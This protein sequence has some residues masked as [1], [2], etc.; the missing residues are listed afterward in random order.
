MICFYIRFI[1]SELCRGTLDDYIKGSYN[2]PKFIPEKEILLQMAKGLVYLHS[3]KIVHRDIKPTNILIYVPQNADTKPVVKLADFGLC[4]VLKNDLES[5]FT[6]SNTRNPSGTQGWMAHELYESNR[7]DSRVDI[8]SLGCVF[9][10]TVTDGKHPFGDDH[11]E[12]LIRIRRNEPISLTQKDLKASYSFDFKA[13]NLIRSMIEWD[14][15]D[16]PTAENILQHD[17]FKDC[18][19][20]TT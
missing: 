18:N 8:F 12:R 9:V 15:K 16:R 20:K 4:K 1:A 13:L 2:G 7:L 11:I 14:P 6:N 5:D 19:L 17:F 3:L 10:Y